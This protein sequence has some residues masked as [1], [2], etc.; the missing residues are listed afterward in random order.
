[1]LSG[2]I[3]YNELA[4]RHP[5]V[6][7]Q[8]MALMKS[9]PQ[10]AQF[11]ADVNR[12]T[13]Q[14]HRAQALFMY[15]ARWADDISGQ[16]A[17]EHPTWHYVNI[18]YIPSDTVDRSTQAPLAAENVLSALSTNVRVI[19]DS[20]SSEADRAIALCWVFHLLGDLHQPLHV[21][22][23]ITPELPNGDRGG[24]LIY[25]VPAL[26]EPPVRL[27][28]FWDDVAGRNSEPSAVI[29]LAR[30]LMRLPSLQ[31]ATLPE[32]Q[33]RPFTDE[34]AF[35]HWAREESYPLAVRIAYQGGTLAAAYSEDRAVVLS[36]FYV[37]SAEECVVRRVVLS[38][39]RL[40]DVLTALFR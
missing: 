11:D 17:Y 15:M 38:G 24:N 8:V 20:H 7:A 5:E 14:A 37:S 39:Y 26:D 18:P 35:E 25:V 21:I 30:R 27:H 2:V 23:M 10:F 9:H 32:L 16:S 19:R 40:A 1:M 4:K 28:M 29:E 33:Q 31:L 34:R 36:S 22:S 12:F 3:A 13:S 6:I